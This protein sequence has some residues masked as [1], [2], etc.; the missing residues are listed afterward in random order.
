MNFERMKDII[1][2][3]LEASNLPYALLIDGTWGSGKTWYIKNQFN[4]DFENK[5]VIYT[6]LNGIN[7]L[8][9]LGKQIIFRKIGLNDNKGEALAKYSWNV[10][11]QLFNGY[12][13]NKTG[14]NADKLKLPEIDPVKLT[15]FKQDEI[16]IIDDIERKGK[17]ISV[18]DLFG[19]INTN[20]T[21]ENQFKVILIANEEKL[22][23]ELNSEKYK[24]IKEKT[25]WQT[26]NFKANVNLVLDNLIANFTHISGNAHFKEIKQFILSKI[27]EYEINNLRT[28]SFF[29]FILDEIF[30]LSGNLIDL[31][32]IKQVSVSTLV[33]C[34]EFKSGRIDTNKLPAANYLIHNGILSI[35]NTW[36]TDGFNTQS[37]QNPRG[38]EENEFNQRYFKS[39][40]QDYNFFQSI[41]DLIC[42]GSF[43]EYKF[44]DE[45]LKLIKPESESLIEELINPLVLEQSDFLTKWDSL[46]L[47]IKDND[48]FLHDLLNIA[49][50]FEYYSLIDLKFPNKKRDIYNILKRKVGSI[51]I[52]YDFYKS[53]INKYY[54]KVQDDNFVGVSQDFMDLE[55]LIQLRSQEIYS[56]SL[57]DQFNVFIK[58]MPVLTEITKEEFQIFINRCNVSQF[59]D[60]ISFAIKNTKIA[61]Q[62]VKY[63]N[64][65]Y[66][67][68]SE[69]ADKEIR[70]KIEKLKAGCL[71]RS[72]NGSIIWAN[73][74]SIRAFQEPYHVFEVKL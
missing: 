48:C 55:N 46:I 7:S 66:Y 41:F 17:D 62:I 23:E 68:Y 27:N 2:R 35:Q 38:K 20:F 16:L 60:F 64:E 22:I 26:I 4:T 44:K 45:I 19:F 10:A 28:V 18:E 42:K 72:K 6:S 31:R 12:I 30:K 3:Y 37:I 67:W 73:Y 5:K 49:G 34:N 15:T 32:N 74:N 47:F 63:I 61:H 59:G 9:D 25:I 58:K 50:T 13:E 57:M 70:T 51:S 24:K 1:T 40:I 14:L 36:I 52:P 29:L 43:D 56:N 54:K 65:E 11:K 53:R 8:D 33:L 39:G 21:E 69:K 71:K